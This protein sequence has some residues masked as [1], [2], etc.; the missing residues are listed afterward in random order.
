M[1]MLSG[2]L[3]FLTWDPPH[4]L[5]VCHGDCDN[6]DQCEGDSRCYYNGKGETNVPE[7]CEGTALVDADYCYAPPG[8]DLICPNDVQ[9]LSLECCTCFRNIGGS[10][11]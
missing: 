4:V 11:R 8:N 7:G 3:Q 10:R 2:T 5:A 6:D 1:T 9:S